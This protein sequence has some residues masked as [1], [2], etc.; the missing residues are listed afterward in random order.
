MEKPRLFKKSTKGQNK[1][2]VSPRLLAA[3]KEMMRDEQVSPPEK[4]RVSGLSKS[5]PLPVK[6]NML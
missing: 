2:C 1:G 3:R 6:S 4:Q 5:L